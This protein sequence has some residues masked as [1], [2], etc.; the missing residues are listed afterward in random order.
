MCFSLSL[1]FCV[2]VGLS[3]VLQSGSALMLHSF[4]SVFFEMDVV[5]CWCRFMFFDVKK[6]MCWVPSLPAS[7]HPGSH[8]PKGRRKS[9]FPP[10]AMSAQVACLLPAISLGFHY[11]WAFSY[12]LGFQPFVPLCQCRTS[13]A[14]ATSRR[15]R[16]RLASRDLSYFFFWVGLS[17][18]C[19]RFYL[20]RAQPNKLCFFS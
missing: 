6:Y 3:V 4:F 20:S 7:Q 13:S 10:V 18:M 14:R 5:C 15:T 17:A 12:L 16:R 8:P 2:Y 9:L 11:Y 1:L 19:S